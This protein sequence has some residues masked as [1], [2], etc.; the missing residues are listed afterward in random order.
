MLIPGKLYR[1]IK[2]YECKTFVKIVKTKKY[3]NV[4]YDLQQE[5]YIQETLYQRPIIYFGIHAVYISPYSTPLMDV[6]LLNGGFIIIPSTNEDHFE[7][8]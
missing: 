7:L 1:L 5:Y 2:N 6:W 8:C 4:D 3:K